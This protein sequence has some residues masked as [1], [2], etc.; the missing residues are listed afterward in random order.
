VKTVALIPMDLVQRAVE[1]QQAVED[2]ANGLG[3]LTRSTIEVSEEGND[4]AIF[5]AYNGTRWQ[6]EVVEVR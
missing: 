1:V 2:A 5:V 6:L 4:T 3:R